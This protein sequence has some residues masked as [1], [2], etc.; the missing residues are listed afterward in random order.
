MVAFLRL[1]FYFKVDIPKN[2]AYPTELGTVG[3][4]IR[5]VRINRGDIKMMLQK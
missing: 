2:P 1:T 5:K 4:H 3:D